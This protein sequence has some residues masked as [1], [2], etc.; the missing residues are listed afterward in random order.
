VCV[1]SLPRGAV[2]A[3]GA[4]GG[5]L[6]AI[7]LLQHAAISATLRRAATILPI[8]IVLVVLLPVFVP[9]EV[10]FRV[11][12]LS[13]S[14]PGIVVALHVA[15]VALLC[16][17]AVVLVITSTRHD[18]LLLALRGLRVPGMLVDTLGMMLRYVDVVRPELNRL[19]DAR[20]A[21]TIGVRGPGRLRT[22]AGVLGASFVRAW[23]RAG[24]VADAMAA[25][26]YAGHY[27]MVAQKRIRG[28][29]VLIGSAVVVGLVA[30]RCAVGG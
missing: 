30:V 24:R 6:V 4:F 7:L 3:Y 23:D 10:A 14:R 19:R 13:L 25:R 27:R 20:A 8:I 1:V 21:R 26:G 17:T 5:L 28:R 12:A 11:G 18:V 15:C 22:T 2:G 9:G 16:V 29:D